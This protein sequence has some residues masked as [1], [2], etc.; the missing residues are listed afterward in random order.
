MNHRTWIFSLLMAVLLALSSLVC[1]GDD[2]DDDDTGD[3]D[4]G[5]DDDT[6]DDDDDD[7]DDNDDDNLHPPEISNAYWD[8]NPVSWNDD[9]DAW[10]SYLKFYVCDLDSDLNGGGAVFAYLTGTDELIWDEPYY[11]NISSMWDISDCDNPFHVGFGKIF[12]E[13]VEPPGWNIDYCVDLEVSDGAGLF[14]NK[15][16]NICV[17]V[18]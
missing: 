8:T 12:T 11:W 18:P 4:T 5:D 10:I 17:Y 16:N 6:S 7:D 9:L 13:T 2:D 14:S 1:T 3:D 15:I